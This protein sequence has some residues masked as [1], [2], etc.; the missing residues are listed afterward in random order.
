M[1]NV[2]WCSVIDMLLAV[3]LVLT[4]SSVIIAHL[5]IRRLQCRALQIAMHLDKA[6]QI[7]ERMANEQCVDQESKP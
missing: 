3:A 7:I 1:S 4:T 2:Y 5:R 6:L